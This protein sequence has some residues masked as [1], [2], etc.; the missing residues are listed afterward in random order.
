MPP[1]TPTATPDPSSQE[2]K[3]TPV[4]DLFKES[5]GGGADEQTNEPSAN[6]ALLSFMTDNGFIQLEEGTKN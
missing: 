6:S 5:E 3:G 4:R 2:N 1:E